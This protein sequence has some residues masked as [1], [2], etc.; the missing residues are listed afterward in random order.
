MI[1]I[2]INYSTLIIESFARACYLDLE[3]VLL[4]LRSNAINSLL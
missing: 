1:E 3:T 4:L 2:N